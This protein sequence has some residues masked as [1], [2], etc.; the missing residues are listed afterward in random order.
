MAQVGGEL[1]ELEAETQSLLYAVRAPVARQPLATDKPP[2]RWDGTSARSPTNEAGGGDPATSPTATGTTTATFGR[3]RQRIHET[4]DDYLPNSKVTSLVQEK[5][6]FRVQQELLRRESADAQLGPLPAPT[7]GTGLYRGPSLQLPKLHFAAGGVDD[8]P[9]SA[10]SVRSERSLGP[11]SGRSWNGFADL[12]S[13]FD[14]EDEFGY[15]LQAPLARVNSKVMEPPAFS[16][17]SSNDEQQQQREQQ[18][19]LVRPRVLSAASIL[20]LGATSP[21]PPGP[22]AHRNSTSAPTSLT[23]QESKDAMLL[24]NDGKALF[25]PDGS[26]N[27]NLR[28]TVRHALRVTRFDSVSTI[29]AH[30]TNVLGGGNSNKT[31]AASSSATTGSATTN[32]ELGPLRHKAKELSLA[33]SFAM[34]GKRGKKQRPPGSPLP[35]DQ[36]LDE[37]GRPR[38]LRDVS[39]GGFDA[40]SVDIH[41]RVGNGGGDDDASL[42]QQFKKPDN[43]CFGCWSSG[44]GNK[45][46]VHQSSLNGRKGSES[47]LICRNWDL[48][49]LRFRYVLDVSLCGRCPRAPP[50]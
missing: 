11:L 14:V 44:N 45:C 21:T 19:Q 33:A 25:L 10:S 2:L 50:T 39:F 15:N 17:S 13:E 37:H 47:M 4:A 30:D 36:Q 29:M 41:H 1:Q 9:L 32:Y 48:G 35:L 31:A 18:Q 46:A 6:R 49:A 22:T 23:A 8:R 12:E 7:G 28:D 3:E 34:G 40:G 24:R 38:S 16:P 42:L 26:A 27:I 20:R 43:V 5:N